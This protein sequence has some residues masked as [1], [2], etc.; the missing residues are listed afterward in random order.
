MM[1]RRGSTRQQRIG[2][3]RGVEIYLDDNGNFRTEVEAKCGALT[4][5]TLPEIRELIDEAGTVAKLNA[6]GFMLDGR[7][8]SFE[9]RPMT[10]TS[11]R[12][13]T[14]WRGV[15]A[16]VRREGRGVEKERAESVYRNTPENLA[17]AKEYL[18]LKR[19][20]QKLVKEAEKLQNSLVSFEGEVQPD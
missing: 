16:F 8:D 18:A 5:P 11:V 4:A 14:G 19:Q 7:Y 17:K 12:R 20:I 2:E 6:P 13:D 1:G 3:W 9:I 15:T 10:V